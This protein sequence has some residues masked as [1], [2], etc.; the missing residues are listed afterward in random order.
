M[1]SY[2]IGSIVLNVSSDLV[3]LFRINPKRLMP[4]TCDHTPWSGLTFII[5]I[6]TSLTSNA[7]IKKYIYTNSENIFW[8]WFEYQNWNDIC[9]LY[10]VDVQNISI[11]PSDNPLT[12]REGTQMEVRCVV[13]SNAV[14]APNITWSLGSTYITSIAGTYTTSITLTGNRTDNNKTLQCR[15]TNN[16]KTPKT[17]STVLNIECEYI[18]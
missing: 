12:F 18:R 17:A 2:L 13:N 6:W 3:Y 11:S 4:F 10:T 9:F 15:A 1:Y 5:E 16:N 14:P 7:N 8:I